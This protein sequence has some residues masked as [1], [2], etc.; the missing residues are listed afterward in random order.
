MAFIKPISNFYGKYEK[1]ISS[2]FLIGGF[3]FDTLTLKRVDAVFE[4]LWI[5]GC[6]VIVGIFLILVNI[7]ESDSKMHFWYANILQFFIGSTLSAYLVFY[8]R[9]TEFSSTWP[10]IFL[11][12]LA[13]IANESFKKNNY[14]LT[15]QIGLFFLSIYSFCIFFIPVTLHTISTN[16]FLLSGVVSLAVI[17]LYVYLL[18]YFLKYKKDQV[19]DSKRLIFSVVLGI[20]GLVNF[21]YFTNLIPPIPL[22]LKDAGVYH[23]IQRVANGYEVT[24]ED[25]SWREY[26]KIYPEFNLVPGQPAYVFSAVFSPKD[27]NLTIIHEWQHY[28]EISNKW[29]TQSVIRLPVVGGRD[30]GFRTYSTKSSMILGKWR[31]NIKTQDGLIIGRKRFVVVNSGSNP[32]LTSTIK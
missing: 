31:V 25:K 26:F 23:S 10:F 11:L 7:K 32:I 20:F 22:S 13:F 27:L 4:N 5:L 19:E 24:Y 8:F 21:L 30:N 1:S 14:R 9:S 16:I 17:T 15:F 3:I 6:L 18:F 29:E 12:T 2:L 28:N